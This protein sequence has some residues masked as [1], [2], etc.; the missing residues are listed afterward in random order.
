VI[1]PF[2]LLEILYFVSDDVHTIILYI[3]KQ[4]I[5]WYVTF[6]GETGELCQETGIYGPLP[7]L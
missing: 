7:M 6:P 5:I 2:C 4:F 1:V 3:Q